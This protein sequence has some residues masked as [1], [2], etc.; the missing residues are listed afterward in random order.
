MK[1]RFIIEAA[2]GALCMLLTSY[3]GNRGFLVCLVLS[4][5]FIIVNRKHFDLK[6]FDERERLLFYK[7]GNY[8]VISAFI[9]TALFNL[10]SNSIV[11]GNILSTYW[12][13]ML[14]GVFYFS[15]GIT[16]F[17]VFLRE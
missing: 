14:Y 16:G 17:V 8:T 12:Y 3:L 9:C 13:Q 10:L 6:R 1:Q 2:I 7:T 15:H 5:V 11:H 4:F